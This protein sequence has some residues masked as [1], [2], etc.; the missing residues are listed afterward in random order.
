MKKQR[1]KAGFTLIEI[2]VVLV[3]LLILAGIVV[4]AAKY[5]ITKGATSR[6]QAEIASME[7]ALESYKSDNGIY[8][9]S[10]AASTTRALAI[11]NAVNDSI[12]LYT[13]LT[14]PKAY[15]TFKPGQ[16]R[17]D[18]VTGKT[19]IV[20][21]FGL[22]YNYYCHPIAGDQKNSVTFDLWSYGPDNQNDTGDDITNWKQN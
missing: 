4:G 9:S 8:P 3:I 13:A 18:P 2:L 1:S 12:S 17:L 11:N 20:D 5:A 16:L 14:T 15:M 6:A 7:N 19:Y 22:P 10:D 21:P